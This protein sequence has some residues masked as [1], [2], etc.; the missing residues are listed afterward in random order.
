MIH[1]QNL[2]HILYTDLDIYHMLVM[3]NANFKFNI[4]QIPK[5]ITIIKNKNK[6]KHTHTQSDPTWFRDR[7]V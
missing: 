3:L 1:K 6:N 4:I 7:P 2:V 5:D